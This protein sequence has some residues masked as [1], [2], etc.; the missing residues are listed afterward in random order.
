MNRLVVGIVLVGAFCACKSKPSE[1]TPAP[2][3]GDT[4]AFQHAPGRCDEVWTSVEAKED[5][6]KF[7]AFAETFAG[8]PDDW[9]ITCGRLSPDE[10]TC[11]EN[12]KLLADLPKVCKSARAKL[13]RK[14]RPGASGSAQEFKEEARENLEQIYQGA[15]QY[16]ED[17]PPGSA[18]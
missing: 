1:K 10:L 3:P 6:G 11:V 5:F 4:L 13:F 8:R 16:Y 17:A 7:A 2:E 12:T 14:P 15:K 18:D 9:T